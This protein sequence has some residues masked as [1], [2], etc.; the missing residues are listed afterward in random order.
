MVD[1]KGF[2]ASG[3]KLYKYCG[4]DADIN[5]PRIITVIGMDAFS[6]L[7]PYQHVKLPDNLDYLNKYIEIY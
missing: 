1:N 5:V 3:N 4:L 6:D 2:V 7:L